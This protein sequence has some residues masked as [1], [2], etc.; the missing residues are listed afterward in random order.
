MQE[1]WTQSLWILQSALQHVTCNRQSTVSPRTSEC[2][3]SL[4]AP[5]ILLGGEGIVRV[6]G[7]A[8]EHN[9]T[10]LVRAQPQTDPSGVKSTNH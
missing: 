6:E 3:Q 9:T 10:T 4:Q 7:L 5:S 8:K 2:L 1:H